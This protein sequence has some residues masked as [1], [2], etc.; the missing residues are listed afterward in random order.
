[1]VILF[2]LFVE[3]FS[4]ICNRPSQIKYSQSI[5]PGSSVQST[6]FNSF[7]SEYR[8]FELREHFNIGNQWSVSNPQRLFVRIYHGVKLTMCS[9]LIR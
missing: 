7:P 1:M 3:V 4:S 2:G 9:L 5:S 8:Q 6:K